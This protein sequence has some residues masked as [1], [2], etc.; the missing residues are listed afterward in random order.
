MIEI[1]SELPARDATAIE[2]LYDAT[3]GPGHFA[4]TAERLREHSRSVPSISHVARRQGVVIGV[5]RVWPIEVGGAAALFYGPVAVA[6]DAQGDRL[7]LAV[8]RA[9]LEAG[10]AAGWPAALL[11]GAPSYFSRIG[12][13]PVPAG[14]V[15][16]PGPQDPQR[17]MAM[18]LARSWSALGG[19]VRAAPE[20][21]TGPDVMPS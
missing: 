21:V 12:F 14:Q 18:D 11:I 19:D 5:C 6:P 20:L 1:G 15:R 8:T 13:Q 2:A 4:K 16:F 3:F 7:G 9:A 10:R 17:V